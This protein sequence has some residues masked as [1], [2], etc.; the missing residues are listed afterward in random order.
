MIKDYRP[1]PLTDF[2]V[3]ENRKAFEL[4]L[5]KVRSELGNE[6]PLIIN[7]EKIF[8]KEK[9]ISYN[10]SKKDEVVGYVSKASQA[11][12]E[13]AVQEAAKVFEEW[14][15]WPADAR[16]RLLFKAAAIM[17]RRKHEMSA[18]MVLEAGK[19][20]PE[21]DGDTAEAIDF[22]EYYGRQ[23]IRL[24][25]SMPVTPFEGETND[26]YYISLGVGIVIPPW[27]FPL[28][29]LVGMTTAAAVAGNTVI[30]KPASVTPV[31]GAKFMEIME[32]AGMPNGVINFL[33]G[34]GGE[35]GDYL[36]DHPMTRFINFTGSKEIGL[37]IIERA[38]KVNPGQKWIK[39][40]VAEMGGKDAVL[41]NNDAD[42]EAASSAIVASAFGYQ[43][44]KC[45]AGSRAIIHRDVYDEVLALVVEKTK[46]LTKGNPEDGK[47]YFG[48]VVDKS[49][50]EN[51]K[52]Y[53]EI[54]KKEARLMVGGTS[55]DSIG[56]FI[57]PT[58]FAD[59]DPD[60][61]I[62]QEEIFGPILT[63]IKAED[64]DDGFRIFNGTEF[65]LT[66]SLY[67]KDRAIIERGRRE[68]HCGNLYF[69]RKS[70][71]A[72]VGVHPFGGFNM[73]GTDSKTG[74]ED[75]LLLFMQAKSISEA[76]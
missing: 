37:R 22:I 10:P 36:V 74:S 34:S 47:V 64:I 16:A 4:A 32:E 44:Q 13:K 48:P 71:G 63:I 29:I 46:V 42:L 55:D 27:N 26:N 51:V 57:E 40:V 11:Q 43:G 20:W 38:A 62:S 76:L 45:S 65:G 5:K 59:T 31:I 7:G 17:R 75:Y 33:P 30:L 54:G 60:A 3:E 56:Y 19:S 14:K 69:N 73:S 24:G 49:A 41:V 9:I 68:L 35:V 2:S 1:E 15:N 6:Y 25:G 18:T 8:T 50:Y 28:A 72:S 66:G 67:A 21:A 61:V 23:M 70:T 52:R 12:A 39:R 53:I 58:I